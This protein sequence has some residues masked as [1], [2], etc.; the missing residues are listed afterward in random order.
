MRR[1]LML[2][3]ALTVLLF[4]ACALAGTRALLV[5]CK[6]FISQPD[7][8]SASSGNLHMIGSAL[9]GADPRL[10]VLSIEDGTIGTPEALGVSISSAFGSADEDDLSILYLCTHGVVSS[11]DDGQVYLLLGDGETES[12]LSAAQLTDMVAAIPGEKLLIIDACYSGAL[13]GRGMSMSMPDLLL[14]D[15]SIH[16]LTS[17]DGHESSWY[18]DSDHLSNGALSYFASAFSSGLGL[19]GRPEADSDGDGSVTLEEM[20]RYLSVSVPSSSSQL[21]SARSASLRLPVTSG[22]ML[23]RPLTGFA[24]STSLLRTDDPVLSF[25]FTAAQDTAVQYRLVEYEAGQ[26]NWDE[27][28]VFLDSGDDGNGLISTGRHTRTLTLSSIATQDSGYLMLQ[29]FSMSGDELIL[30]SERLIGI[31]P[32]GTDA[33]LSLACPPSAARG[34]VPVRVSLDVPAEITVCVYDSE[35]QLVRRLCT[36][37]LTRPSPT[38]DFYLHW[39][40]CD[41]QGQPAKEGVYAITAEA[42]IGERRQSAVCEVDI[43][44]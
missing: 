6:E 5:A 1:I 22:A 31:Q 18:Y 43:G 32:A 15:P 24:Y 27:A 2:I 44:L 29:V 10:E 42:R 12:P 34:P 38:G 23:S 39:D 20:H 37:Q 33:P 41:A 17:A 28:Q 11:S 19:Y 16:V 14:T 30:C 40:G 21:H 13:I 8:G 36:G 7:L 3:F 26:W 4:P 9:I 35:G 25:S